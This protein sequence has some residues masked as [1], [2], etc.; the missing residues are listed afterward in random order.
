ME[1]TFV[2]PDMLLCF[3]SAT[4]S[5]TFENVKSGFPNDV[6][7]WSSVIFQQNPFCRGQ[8]AMGPDAGAGESPLWSVMSKKKNLWIVSRVFNFIF[9]IY[10]I[11]FFARRMYNLAYRR[12]LDSNYSNICCFSSKTFHRIYDFSY[13][14]K[15]CLAGSVRGRHCCSG[16]SHDEKLG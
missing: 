6:C 4:Q 12:D 14:C 13:I 5:T 11:F 1:C 15:I 3:L 9:L 2:I 8:N 16:K 10:F 7:L